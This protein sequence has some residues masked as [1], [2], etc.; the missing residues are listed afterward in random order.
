MGI[1]D[2]VTHDKLTWNAFRAGDRTAFARLFELHYRQLYSYGK[3]FLTDS[4]LTE[5]AIQDLFIT[6]WRTRSNLSEVDN[7]KFYLFR[8]LRRNIRRLSEREKRSQPQDF[9][10]SAGSLADQ[11]QTPAFT[12]G[13]DEALLNRRLKSIIDQ[14]PRRQRE[15]VLLRYYESF[16]TEEIA[17]LM[18]ISEKTVRNTLFNAMT[19]LR[20]SSHILKACFEILLI[21]FLLS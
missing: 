10:A 8:C 17:L 7:V 12:D 11:L 21:L 15:V 18:G 4:S 2:K 19:T 5:D 14:L 1:E 16:K 20:E 6:L 3:Q 13:N 9:S